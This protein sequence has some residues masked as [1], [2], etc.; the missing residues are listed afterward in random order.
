MAWFRNFYQCYRCNGKWEGKWSCMVDEEC[1]YCDAREIAPY[2]A[3]DLTFLVVQR[4]RDY[5]VLQSPGTAEHAPDYVEI[6][7]FP[8]RGLAEAYVMEVE[9]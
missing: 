7:E 6:A 4:G 8:T 9:E 2:D 5:V 3:A 1:P